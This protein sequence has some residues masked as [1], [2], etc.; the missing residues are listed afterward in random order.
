MFAL[1]LPA[2]AARVSA[3]AVAKELKPIWAGW[4]KVTR[5]KNSAEA[6]AEL[7]QHREMKQLSVQNVPLAAFHDTRAN[8]ET[9]ERQVSEE[10][11]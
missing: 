4:D 2:G 8:I 3:A 5:I 9:V 7:N 1:G 6:V 10:T 11:T